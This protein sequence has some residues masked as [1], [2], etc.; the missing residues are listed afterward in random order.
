MI[1]IAKEV[2][3]DAIKF[4][5]YKAESMTL[6]LDNKNFL[7]KNPNSPFFKKKLYDLYDKSAMPWKWYKKIKLRAKKNKLIFFST[8][9]DK[10]SLDFL[11]T[12]NVPCYKVASFECND[13]PLIRLIAKK[14]KPIIISTGMATFSEIND[15][16]KIVRSTGLK[17]IILL[18]CT[19]SYPA[20]EEDYN[21]SAIPYMRKKF[22]CLIG[23][24]D[25]TLGSVVPVTSISHGAVMIEKHLKFDDKS[26]SADARFSLG[27]DNFKKM[28]DEVNLAF[29]ANGKVYIGPTK[30][31]GISK[32]FRRSIIVIRDIKKNEKITE[33]N[34]KVLR[35]S[36]GISPK[37]YF[38]VLGKKVNKKLKIGDPL[39]F[40]HLKGI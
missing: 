12:L 35:P 14:K 38:K 8:P 26:L 31:E 6:N 34:I 4:Q 1:D 28:V 15:A 9:F 39:K 25:H 7:V 37:Y 11:D 3:A 22:K 18:K 27:P 21:L 40:S 5:T 16:V 2:G 19:S 17:K 13:L 29:K 23:V 36:I 33:K 32:K 20:K 10:Q 30:H 24:S